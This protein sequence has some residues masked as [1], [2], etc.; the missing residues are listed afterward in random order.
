VRSDLIG[1]L[2][3]TRNIA[4]GCLSPSCTRERAAASVSRDQSATA[5][6]IAF[7][8]ASWMICDALAL[9]PEERAARVGARTTAI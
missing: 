6:P 1:S 9:W 4:V 7:S 5:L 8:R 3:P 2:L